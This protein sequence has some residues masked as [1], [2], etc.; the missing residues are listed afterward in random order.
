MKLSSS[1]FITRREFPKDEDSISAKLLVKSGMIIKNDSGI[2]TYLPIGL[3]VIKNIEKIIRSEMKKVKAEEVLMPSLIN[4]EFFKLTNRD[5][6]LEEEM[7]EVYDRNDKHYALCPTHEE[8]FAYLAKCK[9]QSYKDLHFTLFQISNKFRDE[10]HPEFGL[11]RKKEFYMADAYSF[12]SNDGGL[13]VSYDKM[14]QAF[15][16]IFNRIGLDTIVV[17]SDPLYMK[18]LSSEEF[19]I[20]SENG[21]NIVVKC[22]KC[23]YTSNIEE[24]TCRG[25]ESIENASLKKMELV[26]TPNAKTIKDVSY[27]LKINPSKIIKSLVVKVDEK[28]LMILLRGESELNVTKLKKVLNS[29]NIEIPSEY[30]LE[31]IGTYPGFI[32]PIKCTMDIIADN[33]VKYLI[34][35]VCGSNKLNYHYINVVPGRDFSV[36]RYADIKLF[37][38]N[39]KCPKCRGNCDIIKG[40]EVGHI[41]KLGDSYSQ[42]YGLKYVDEKNTLGYVHMGSYGIGIDRCIGALVEKYHDDKGIIWPISVAPYK[43]GIAVVNVNDQYAYKYSMS[44]YDKLN[45]VGIEALIDDRKETIGTKFADLDLI[46]LPFRVT[47]GKKLEEE[48]LVELKLRDEENVRLIDYRDI[49]KEIQII[50]KEK[51]GIKYGK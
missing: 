19:Q 47:V 16:N 37:D 27:C 18:G 15:N 36:N 39:C 50:L 43:V 9:I 13:D 24:A 3:K 49:I 42:D 17:R 26:K 34:N 11:I 41:F 12:D 2:Y 5:K 23:A 25:T 31:K 7:Y 4:N 33:D 21:D 20:I 14:Y 40:I 28:Y 6:L 48:G 44:L 22:S 10:A 51:E 30:E 46:G 8:L 45:E 1:F 32:G 38:E 35:A 29:N